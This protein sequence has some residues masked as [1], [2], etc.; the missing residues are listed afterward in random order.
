MRMLLLAAEFDGPGTV[1][2]D[3]VIPYHVGADGIVYWNAPCE[4]GLTFV[5]LNVDP[6]D[7][8]SGVLHQRPDG[9]EV[10]RTI[11][12]Y[13]LEVD[14]GNGVAVF[15]PNGQRRSMTGIFLVKP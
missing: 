9:S 15:A 5:L 13:R 2:L 10:L 6:T 7:L 4:S 14:N 12:G 1:Q 3:T 8:S 11:D